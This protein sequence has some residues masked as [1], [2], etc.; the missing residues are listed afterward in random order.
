MEFDATSG[1]VFNN[2]SLRITHK[3]RQFDG[4][5]SFGAEQ[6]INVEMRPYV[7]E[8]F[9]ALNTGMNPGNGLLG[10]KRLG[11]GGGDQIGIVQTGKG[12][13]QIAFTD[14]CLCQCGCGS[15]VS[16]QDAGIQA[17]IQVFRSFLRS[18]DDRD[19]VQLGG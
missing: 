6:V 17:L 16:A 18:F 3:F 19:V 1:N 7:K 2:Q 11:D 15:P 4:R 14:V 12:Q 5:Q 8:P 13:K 9:L 10:S